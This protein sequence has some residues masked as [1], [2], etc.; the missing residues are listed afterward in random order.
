[1]CEL[2]VNKTYILSL[3]INHQTAQQY[4]VIELTPEWVKLCS[5]YI[6]DAFWKKISTIQIIKEEK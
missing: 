4:K 5:E 1:M 6:A 2:E 3:D